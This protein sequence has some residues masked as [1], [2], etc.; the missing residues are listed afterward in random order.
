MLDAQNRNIEQFTQKY[1]TEDGLSRQAAE[2]AAEEDLAMLLSLR[3]LVGDQGTMAGNILTKIEG[4][5]TKQLGDSFA[6]RTMDFMN[7]YRSIA[8]ESKTPW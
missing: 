1:M 5:G 6:K 4:I 3:T 2:K 7:K 8:L